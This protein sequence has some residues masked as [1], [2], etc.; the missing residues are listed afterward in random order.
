[1]CSTLRLLFWATPTGTLVP[2][3][4]FARQK[5]ETPPKE[6]KT[7]GGCCGKGK[8]EQ[9]PPPPE[10]PL[11]RLLSVAPDAYWM[12]GLGSFCS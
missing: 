12:M 10:V 1:M 7:K 5:D 11:S 3:L 6:E 4:Y 2:D 8:K 9:P